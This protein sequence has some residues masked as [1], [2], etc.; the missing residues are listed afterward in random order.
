MHV[1]MEALIW[2]IIIITPIVFIHELGHFLFARLFGVKVDVFSIGFGKP[3]LKWK[4]KKD[5][6]WQIAMIPLG[7]YVKM[8]GDENA[9]S[10][11]DVKKLQSLSEEEKK[12]SLHH[13]KLWQKAL[14]VFGGPLANYVL[15]ILLFMGIAMYSGKIEV[16]LEI[17]GV[18]ENSAAQK[19]GMKIGDVIVELNDDKISSIVDLKSKLAL[20][21]KEEI[22]IGYVR[23]DTYF[24]TAITPD[25]VE[26][27]DMIGEKNRQPVIGVMFGKFTY[28]KIGFFESISYSIQQT[29]DMSRNMLTAIWQ[30]VSGQR[31]TD[32]LGGPIKIAKYSV[33][34]A[35]QGFIA[36]LGLVAMISLNLGLVNLLP[37]PMLDG[38]HLFYYA[39]EAIIRRPINHMLQDI[40]FKIG[41]AILIMMMSVA[42]WNDLKGLEFLHNLK[43]MIFN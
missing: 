7:G 35:E 10:T 33:K 9:A 22:N 38:G 21:V 1:S 30:M 42:F 18:Q 17:T 11:P 6:T 27:K 8:H 2:F 36:I 25:F 31:S 43:Q 41:L 3:L 26:V 24:H 37:I 39:I 15:A 23:N 14:I 19:A 12:L 13:K 29:L 40:G 32:D 28:T 4:D 34:F 5:T 16:N 20:N